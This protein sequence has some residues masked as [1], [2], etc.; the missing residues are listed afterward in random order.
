MT[1]YSGKSLQKIRSTIQLDQDKLLEVDQY[2]GSLQGLIVGEVEF[3]PDTNPQTDI[4]KLIE[5]K[6]G[7]IPHDVTDDPR[8]KNFILSEQ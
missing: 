7:I 4:S 1:F 2:L 6:I 8:Y 5:E 3:D